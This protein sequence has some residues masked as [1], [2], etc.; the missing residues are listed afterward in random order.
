MRQATTSSVLYRLNIGRHLALCFALLI[1]MMVVCDGVLLWQL[2]EVRSQVELLKGVD[3]ELI[4]VLRVHGELFSFYERLGLAARSEDQDQLITVSEALRSDVLDETKRTEAAFRHLPSA[5]KVDET[6]FPTIETIQN[7]LLSHLDAI[8]A[9]AASGEW[10]AVRDRT[11]QQV[12]RL[13]FL[14]SQLVKDVARDVEE[15]RTQAALNIALV[16]RRIVFTAIVTGFVTLLTATFFGW[17]TALRIIELRGEARAERKQAEEALRQAQADLT[18]ASRVSSMGELSASLAHEINQ[19]I[20][21]AIT[22]ANSCLR[23]LSRD[24]PDLEEA[25]AA[26]SR[27]VQDGRRAGEI[28]KRVRLLFKKDN[29]QRE[30]VDPNEIVREM[31]LLLRSEAAQFAVFIRTE[32]AADIPQVM[33]DRVQLQ[34]VLMNLMMNSIDAMKDMDGRRELTLQS[35]RG[36]DGQVLI[37]VSDT[38]VGLPPERANMIFDAFFTTKPHGTGMGLRISRSII[39]SHGG[40]LWA[41]NNAPRGAR[42]CFTLPTNADPRDSVVSGDHTGSEDGLQAN[43]PV[44]ETH[45]NR[46]A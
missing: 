44:V 23:W 25:R 34:Q 42:F 18:R 16:E 10:A 24:E 45:P 3:G 13:E 8:R 22:N 21:A 27:I 14:S 30:L 31:M 29:L 9:L 17:A 15:Q 36:E 37:S 32:L 28:I 38:G 26:A 33:G 7:T 6:V 35:Q 41:A 5:V 4:E 39:E 12:Q 46:S 1:L 19:P 43:N 2:R 11:D 20:A 40:R